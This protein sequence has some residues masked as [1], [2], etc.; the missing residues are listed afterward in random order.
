MG[1]FGTRDPHEVKALVESSLTMSCPACGHQNP[2]D[3]R[4]CFQCGAP[5]A[6]RCPQVPTVLPAG[7]RFCNQCGAR[8]D[9]TESDAVAQAPAAYTPKHLAEKILSS[10][11][12]LEGERKQVTVL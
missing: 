4:F 2:S 7:I 10:R 6:R 8:A 5:V 11:R 1:G 9:S 3:S 12:A